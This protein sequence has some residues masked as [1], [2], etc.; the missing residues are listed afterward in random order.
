M[1]EVA[2]D[3]H[4]YCRRQEN[5]TYKFTRPLSVLTSSLLGKTWSQKGSCNDIQTRHHMERPYQVGR[6]LGKHGYP[7]TKEV[8]LKKLLSVMMYWRAALSSSS[9]VKLVPPFS[10]RITSRYIDYIELAIILVCL[11]NGDHGSTRSNRLFFA[12]YKVDL[13][14]LRYSFNATMIPCKFNPKTFV[15][16]MAF[17][18]ATQN[19]CS[20]VGSQ[21]SFKFIHMEDFF[22]TIDRSRNSN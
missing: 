15:G 11:T 17:T 22:F 9:F 14:M 13:L 4:D 19:W 20:L 16:P 3:V 2:T 6:L 21:W 5:I 8:L 12:R 7:F 10:L 18:S 1:A